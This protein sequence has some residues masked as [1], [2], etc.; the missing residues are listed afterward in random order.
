M[1]WEIL[2]L[3]YSNIYLFIA[4]AVSIYKKYVLCIFLTAGTAIFSNLFHFA[5]NPEYFEFNCI[6]NITTGENLIW[7]IGNNE[8]ILF[9]F[10]D[11]FFTHVSFSVFVLYLIPKKDAKFTNAFVILT[12]VL[13][14][15]MSPLTGL[16]LPISLFVMD[17]WLFTVVIVFYLLLIIVLH[18]LF[19]NTEGSYIDYYKD[20]FDILYLKIG[21]LWVI[22]GLITWVILQRLLG[23]YYIIHPTWHIC[24]ANGSAFFILSIK[25]K[26]IHGNKPR[27]KT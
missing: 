1:L 22:L 15:V 8:K 24:G 4:V 7:T 19:Y 3:V 20:N 12:M 10:G 25:N 9:T 16:Y 21:L 14:G 6:F 2:Y 23:M 18:L 17:L 13:Y 11:F 27:K 26:G 5:L